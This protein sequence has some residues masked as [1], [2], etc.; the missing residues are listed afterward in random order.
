MNSGNQ[1]KEEFTTLT[2]LN[3]NFY[4]SVNE[5]VHDAF[6][7]EQQSE[8]I[9]SIE[10]IEFQAISIPVLAKSKYSG[11]LILFQ[12]ISK[13]LEGEKMQKRFIADAS[14]ELKTPIAVIKGMIEILNRDDFDDEQTRQEFLQQIEVEINRL[15]LLVKDLLQ[16]SK[17]SI[18]NVILKRERYHVNKCIQR[19]IMS[20]EQSAK[21]KQLQ[22]ETTFHDDDMVF[23]DAS[24]MEQVFINLISNA[25][26][27]S[28]FGTIHIRTYKDDI[29]YVC[30]IEDQGKGMKPQ[31]R[32]YIFDRFYRINDDR[33]RISGGSGLGLSIVKSICDAHNIIID[34]QSEYE[35]GTI[36]TL[37]IRA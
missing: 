2:Y 35:K 16:L 8:K 7:L 6:I 28:E 34:V 15:D 19:A 36:F 18:S 26:K 33:S 24:K 1:R 22:I 31:H 13:T 14:H 5:F 4:F 29:Y 20:L 37:K 30:E 11:S 23:I 3:N 27:Y 32:D 25:I 17:L 10:G 12:D 21:D 9:I